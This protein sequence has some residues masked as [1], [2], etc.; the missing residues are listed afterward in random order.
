MVCSAVEACKDVGPDPTKIDNLERT[1]TF[2]RIRYPA[3]EVQA[4][5]FD[6]LAIFEVR[7]S[8]FDPQNWTKVN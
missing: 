1:L 4:K 8:I 7:N 5:K 3:E 6:M 2:T